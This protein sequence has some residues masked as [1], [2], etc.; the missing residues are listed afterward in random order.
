MNT[1]QGVSV[2][3]VVIGVLLLILTVISV[4]CGTVAMVTMNKPVAVSVGLWG[5]YVSNKIS[6]FLVFS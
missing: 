4:L 1:T 2:A 6:K 5:L 3:L